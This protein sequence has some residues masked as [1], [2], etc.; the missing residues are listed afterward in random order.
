MF[1]KSKLHMLFPKLAVIDKDSDD[2][3]FAVV[4]M[5]REKL[6]KDGFG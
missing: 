2:D 6:A 5:M 3:Y 1:L 4:R